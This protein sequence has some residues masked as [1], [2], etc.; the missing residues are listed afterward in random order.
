VK[1][2]VFGGTFDPPHLVHLILAEFAHEQ[3]GLDRVSFLP[4]G[5]P[6]R[7]SGRDLASAADRLAMTSLAVAG[8]DAFDVDAREVVRK[9]PTYTVDT[10]RQIRETLSPH[11]E[12][13][14]ILGQDALAD[15]PSSRAKALRCRRFPSLTTA[16]SPSRCH[17]SAS[18]LPSSASVPAAVSASA[19]SSL[20]P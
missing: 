17:T 12:L 18:A 14:F 20:T 13:F 8:N 4:A 15:L 5:D 1:L 7:K 9:G 11:D 19:T 2:G 3:L 6:W 10:L 16:S